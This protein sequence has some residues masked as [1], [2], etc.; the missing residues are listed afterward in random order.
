VNQRTR[1]VDQLPRA[2]R[3]TKTSRE[4]M[5]A[6]EAVELLG[7][8]RETLYAYASRGLVRSAPAAGSRARLYHRDDIDR[9]RARS[10]ARSGH[11]PVAAS[12]LRWGEPVLET[13]VGSIGEA[14]PLYRGRS[15]VE[16]A[17]E[18]ARFEDVCALLWGGPCGPVLSP[19]DRRLGVPVAHVRGLLRSGA[20]PFD[21]MLVTAA[22]LAAGEPH[23]EPTIDV[24]RA[25]APALF[26]RCIAACGLPRGADAVTA[27][28]EA[29]GAARALLV[30]LGAATTAPRVAAL[31]EALVLSADHELNVSTFAARVAASAGA[32]MPACLTAALGALS[33]PLH[34]GATARVEALVSEIGKPERAPLVVRERLARGDAVAG[35]GHRLYPAGDPRGAR[36]LE[37]AQKIGARSRTVRVLVAATYA[38]ELVARERPTLDVGLVALAAALGLGPGSPLALFACGRLAGYIAHVLE[39]RSAGHLL[40]PRARYV[41]P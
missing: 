28:L 1:N 39:Q 4:W 14:G 20:E 31:Q 33:G 9:L 26:R 35:F 34:G 13:T 36:L 10:Q 15:A 2:F 25:R 16:L 3:P 24:A 32:S 23:A 18:G 19:D 6:K 21:A 41:G 30:A 40:R 11:A 38:M 29:D 8:K 27:S 17:R 7:V 12:A 5:S 22:A 37:L